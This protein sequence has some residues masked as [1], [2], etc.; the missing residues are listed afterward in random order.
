MFQKKSQVS[1]F[2]FS[3]VSHYWNA[4]YKMNEGLVN[5]QPELKGLTKID[6]THADNDTE[7]TE[8]VAET[9]V[10]ALHLLDTLNLNELQVDRGNLLG[11]YKNLI[12]NCDPHVYPFLCD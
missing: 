6:I 1:K 4:N 2:C 5:N 3:L 10:G 7:P 9:P 8:Y 12:A 11:G